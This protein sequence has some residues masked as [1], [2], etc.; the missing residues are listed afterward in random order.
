MDSIPCKLHRQTD[1]DSCRN[2]HMNKNSHHKLLLWSPLL[3]LFE[4]PGVK[5]D[6]GVC[7]CLSWVRLWHKVAVA[8]WLSFMH[9]GLSQEPRAVQGVW[10]L[11]SDCW[12]CYVN[13]ASILEV[14]VDILWKKFYTQ[15]EL[16]NSLDPWMTWKKQIGDF[17]CTSSLCF[18][19][20]FPFETLLRL[21]SGGFFLHKKKNWNWIGSD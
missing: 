3:V 1:A 19:S 13:A 12:V 2:K 5:L 10:T 17:P 7:Q 4:R 18:L 8:P 20:F 6:C 21:L 16:P 14:K 9:W 11:G 15:S